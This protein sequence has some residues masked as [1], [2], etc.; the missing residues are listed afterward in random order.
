MLMLLVSPGKPLP[1]HQDPGRLLT[2]CVPGLPSPDRATP[3]T[4][5]DGP[6]HDRSHTGGARGDG[7]ERGHAH[8]RAHGRRAV[9]GAGT[10]QVAVRRLVRRRHPR[11]PHGVRRSISYATINE[12]YPELE[13]LRI[14][15]DGSRVEQRIK[16]DLFSV[17]ALVGRFASAC[18]VE[19]FTLPLEIKT[20]QYTH[21]RSVVTWVRKLKLNSNK[22]PTALKSW[23]LAAF[24]ARN[25]RSCGDRW[26]SKGCVP[27]VV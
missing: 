21:T 9:R 3:P 25:P 24:P 18:E 2:H 10:A 14:Y 11:Q 13:W 15:T 16:S 26:D 17:Y 6:Q 27:V 1:A 4:A 12:L 7:G 19:A 20:F 23:A 5:S 22:C 8:R